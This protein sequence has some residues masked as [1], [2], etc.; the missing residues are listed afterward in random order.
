MTCG[1]KLPL[2]LLLAGAFF[3]DN[4]ATVM[5]SIML[6]GWIFALLI[7]KLLRSTIV[8]GEATPFVM[9]LPPYRLPTLFSVILHCWERAWQYIKKAGTVLLAISV[10]IWGSMTFPQLPE[11]MASPFESRIERLNNQLEQEGTPENIKTSLKAEIEELENNLDEAKL[12]WSIAGRMGKWL[13]P[14]TQWAGFD[15][16]TDI[17]LLAGVAA[18]EAVVSTLGTAWAMGEQDP[19]EPESLADKLKSAPGWSAATALALMLFVLLYSPCFVALVVIKQEAGSWG[20]LFFSIIF[21]TA[22]AFI[23]AIITYQS[24]LKLW[25]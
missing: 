24:C 6:A 15:W 9:E 19:D 2:L 3:P 21:N 22:L 17:A 5:F 1:A 14:V 16:R 25:S 18:K 10:I 20:W 8:K 13:E 4:A 23:V 12:S 11:E 7:A